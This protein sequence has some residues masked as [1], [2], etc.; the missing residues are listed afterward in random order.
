MLLTF[1]FIALAGYFLIGIWLDSRAYAHLIDPDA[2]LYDPPIAKPEK[3][4]PAGQEHRRRAVRFWIIGG[5][6]V[7]LLFW[8]VG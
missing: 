8:R 3:F 1:K 6:V 4:T 5:I 2:D 7:G